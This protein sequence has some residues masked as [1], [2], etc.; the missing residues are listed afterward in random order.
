MRPYERRHFMIAETF[1]AVSP[2]SL[3][4]HEPLVAEL[5]ILWTNSA[6]RSP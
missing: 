1:G 5:C 6:R 4:D 2:K 3:R